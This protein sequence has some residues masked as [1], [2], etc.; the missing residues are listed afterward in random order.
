MFEEIILVFLSFVVSLTYNKKDKFF[1]RFFGAFFQ[2]FFL[3]ISSLIIAAVFFTSAYDTQDLY[4]NLPILKIFNFLGNLAL[5]GIPLF[6][7]ISILILI[8]IEKK[9]NN[10]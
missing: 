2:T 7:I 3:I 1:K 10:L 8:K 9:D 5:Y 4:P 6:Y